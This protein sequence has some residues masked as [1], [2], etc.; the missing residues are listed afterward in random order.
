MPETISAQAGES[1][2]AVAQT[3]AAS[4]PAEP[5]AAAANAV[6]STSPQATPATA[7]DNV[8]PT[9]APVAMVS[10]TTAEPV[11]G[12]SAPEAMQTS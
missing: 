8:Q 6:V 7:M 10:D 2:T 12:S 4:Q 9:D 3:D 5:V 11:E 1:L